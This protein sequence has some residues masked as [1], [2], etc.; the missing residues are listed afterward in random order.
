M[1][2]GVAEMRA[3]AQTELAIEIPE[4]AMSLE[5]Q[6]LPWD[7]I[8]PDPQQP[9]VQADDELKASIAAGGIRQPITVRPRPGA[10]G[11]YQIVDG[12]RRWRGAQGVQPRLPCIVRLDMDDDAERVRTQLIANTGKPLT[13]VE[14][15]RAMTALMA[16]RGGSI[17]DLAA[18]VGKPLT[19]VAQRLNLMQLGPWLDLIQR[20]A[21]KYTHAAE[22]LLRY[23]GCPDAVHEFVIDSLGGGG[24]V[25]DGDSWFASAEA[26]ERIVEPL[27]RKHLYPI[28][29]KKYDPKPI[30]E[31]ASHDRECTCGGIEMKDW[32]GFKRRYCGNPEWWQPKEK[33]AKKEER[34]K[35]KAAAEKGGAAATSAKSASAAEPQWERE[36]RLKR[37]FLARFREHEAPALL[38]LFVA[39]LKKASGRA[40]GALDTYVCELN[41]LVFPSAEAE[42]LLARGKDGDDFMRWIA[43]GHIHYTVIDQDWNFEESLKKCGKAFGID[44]APF[45]KRAKVAPAPAVAAAEPKKRTKGK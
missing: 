16:S 38:K 27:Y 19:T 8:F 40:G 25:A 43:F 26:F 3:G 14:E 29:K 18:Y 32:D 33:A 13:P 5:V 11:Q 28:A 39:A 36:D 22:V 20:G 9:R 1:G 42:K 30:F 45:I 23:R 12:E 10:I 6:Y 44:V 31:T 15:A 35:A 37:E 17:A 4:T 7:L 34:A 41:E 21:I 24:R 2:Q